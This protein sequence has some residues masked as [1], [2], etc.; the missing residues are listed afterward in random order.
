L[1]VVVKFKV[2]QTATVYHDGKC[3]RAKD[4]TVIKKEGRM[5]WV[6]LPDYED[7]GLTIRKMRRLRFL[8]KR[9]AGPDYRNCPWMRG[10]IRCR[11]P[12]KYGY[13]GF[14]PSSG[15]LDYYTLGPFME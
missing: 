14:T 3:G 4:A 15:W 9:D 10:S 11:T 5:V 2:G 1:G 8:L 12:R 13:R 7:D 6:Y